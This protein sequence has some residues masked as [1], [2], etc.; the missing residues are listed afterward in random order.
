MYLNKFVNFPRNKSLKG[1][2]LL[3]LEYAVY[4]NNFINLLHD[5]A[6]YR[7]LDCARFAFFLAG[8]IFLG[9]SIVAVSLP[10]IS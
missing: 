8:A 4:R 3:A 6:G 7:V 10:I 1:A 5:K 2:N 9:I